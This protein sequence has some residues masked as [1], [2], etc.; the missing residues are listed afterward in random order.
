MG[1]V[2]VPAHQASKV[3][4]G[5]QLQKAR[6]ISPLQELVL[7]LYQRGAPRASVAKL[8]V[9]Q[10][11]D[12]RYLPGQ[13]AK[14]HKRARSKLRQMEETQWFRDELYRRTV[15]KTDLAVPVIMEGIV[16]KA[17]RGDVPAAKFAM[18]IAGRYEEKKDAPVASVVL[19]FGGEIPRPANRADRPEQA[20]AADLEIEEAEWALI[21]SPEEADEAT[22]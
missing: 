12:P 20:L 13:D 19:N 14:R 7:Q 4:P 21:E 2:A 6:P 5:R 3:Q 9:D 10:L 1:S 17:T 16:A 11:V 22:L 18:E 15:V 8:L